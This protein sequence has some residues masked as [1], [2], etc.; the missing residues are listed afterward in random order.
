[1][2][3]DLVPAL[4]MFAFV[5]SITP[6]PNNLMLMASGANFGFRQSIPHMLG[7]GIGFSVMVLLVGAGLVQVFDAYPISHQILKVGSVIYLLYLAWKIANAAPVTAGDGA[8]K[9]MTFVQA[10]AFQW[11][12]PKAWSMGLT[13]VSAYT[14]DTTLGAIALVALVFGA[15][16][17]P[18]ITV[19]TV[20]G[21]QMARVLT[22][23]TRLVVFNWTM[24]ALLVVSLYPVVFP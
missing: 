23:R 19:W 6:G 20:M 24:G 8:G 7:I 11:V 18:S 2:N 14:P 17:L 22:N 21:Q 10:A 16:N 1:M 13:A 3:F 12:N 9:P 5:S 4:A 15:I